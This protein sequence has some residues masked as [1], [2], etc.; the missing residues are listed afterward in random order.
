MRILLVEDDPQAGPALKTGLEAQSYAVDLE[1][2]GEKGLYRAKTNDYDFIILDNMLP[3]KQG[4]EICKELRYGGKMMPIMMLTVQ[5][6]VDQKVEVLNGGADDYLT[7]PY[8]L[9]ELSARIRALLRR[10]KQME[11]GAH[12][13]VDDLVLD[14]VHGTVMRGDR[15]IALAPKEFA[16][17]EYLMKNQGRVMG[18]GAILEHVWDANADMFSNTIEAHIGSLRRKIDRH[19]KRK[20]IHTVTGRGYKV[21]VIPRKRK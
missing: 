4:S 15:A 10:P 2:D 6:A 14:N 20:L 13:V 18:R 11:N 1:P 9:G 8:S 16:L 21:D 19:G 17:L 7:K 12:L 5:D 3:G